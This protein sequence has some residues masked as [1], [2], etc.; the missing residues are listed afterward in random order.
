ML[1][2]LCPYCMTPAKPGVCAGC[3]AELTERDLIVG[4]ADENAFGDS[5]KKTEPV[6]SISLASGEITVKSEKAKPK[7]TD[8]LTDMVRSGIDNFPPKDAYKLGIAYYSGVGVEQDYKLA[9]DLFYSAAS[10][11][12]NKALFNL[13]ECARE[14]RGTE[15]DD[16]QAKFYYLLGADKSDEKCRNTLKVR[17]GIVVDGGCLKSEKLGGTGLSGDFVQLVDKLY[18][19]VVE[20]HASSRSNCTGSAGS[21]AIVVGDYVVTNSH[22]ILSGN[23]YPYENI[24]VQV[25]DAPH[26]Y[27]VRT[28]AYVPHEDVAVLAFT[29]EKPPLVYGERL[30]MRSALTVKAGE[31]VFTIGNPNNMGL[32]VSKG[33]V[34]RAAERDNM[35]RMVLRTDMTINH[36][37]S[38]GPLFDSA[39]NVVGLMTYTVSAGGEKLGDMSFAVISDTVTDIIR[40]I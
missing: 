39:G 27:P 8:P 30:L 18:T 2:K 17:Y 32:N 7:K 23:G 34:S 25:G 14:G 33:I 16:E 35:G 31:D 9:H 22:V 26:R 13:G 20:V 10:R 29:G 5:K 1:T 36:G 21:G 11:G 38:G 28:V 40:K 15:Q 6:I 37:N 12:E 19:N 24:S 4:E 3:N